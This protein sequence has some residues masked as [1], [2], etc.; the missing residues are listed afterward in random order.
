MAD[1][2]AFALLPAVLEHSSLEQAAGPL[3]GHFLGGESL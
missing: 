2:G 3:L 1:G